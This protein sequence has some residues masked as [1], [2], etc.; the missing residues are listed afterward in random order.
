MRIPTLRNMIGTLFI[1]GAL[2][3]CSQGPQAEAATAPAVETAVPTPAA[4]ERE[5]IDNG[6]IQFQPNAIRWYTN[7]DLAPNT[8]RRFVLSAQQGQQ[9]S[10]WLATQPGSESAS[11]AGLYITGADGQALT[12][13]PVT[14]WSDLL[15]SSQDYTLEIVSLAPQEI[16]YTLNLEIPAAV[17]DLAAGNKYEPVD[18]SV[19]QTIQEL[20]VQGLGIE[21]ALQ[22]PAPFLDAIAGEAGQGCRL[23]AA[24]NGTQ[25]AS[26]QDVVA[27]LTGSAG[28]SWNEQLTYQADGPTGSST[29]LSRDMGLMIT[30]ASW[31]P[32]MG[33]TCPDDRPLADCD[34]APEQKVYRIRIDVAQYRA[35]F[36]LDGHWV[37]AAGNFTL[38]LY[39]DWK[40]IYGR[41]TVVAQAGNKI[42]AL[43]VS[44]QGK[45]Q[46]HTAT[47]QFQSS[48][49]NSPGTA[50]ITYLDVNTIT[51]KI[52]A[53]PEGEYY[54][55][56]E[57]T[58]TRQ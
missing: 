15:P 24:G 43:D 50:E 37:D 28:L 22:T 31:E 51:W 39:Q 6:R 57:A 11:Q 41:H 8:A 49:T 52:V 3:G 27:A 4:Q 58:L 46:G 1:L 47:V 29:A 34:L 38:D 53:P 30:Q 32:A 56:A 7:G 35:D 48:F 17:I 12:P 42:D 36:S 14:Y 54:L 18:L 55:P 45:L 44:I 40:D 26:P 5:T 19:C 13:N 23:T 9:M 2:A 33:V 25:F 20:A 21:F 16:L 10:V